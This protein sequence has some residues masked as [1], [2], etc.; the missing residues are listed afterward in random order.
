MRYR[1]Y[2]T[3]SRLTHYLIPSPAA[4]FPRAERPLDHPAHEPLV[5]L[6]PREPAAIEERPGDRRS[7]LGRVIGLR[8]L[9]ALL[10]AGRDRAE[11]GHHAGVLA[12]LQLGN[13]R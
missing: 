7:E 13:V 6:L 9:A 11:G 3:V 4:S 1:S 12:R 2:V 10:G 5:Q 8:K